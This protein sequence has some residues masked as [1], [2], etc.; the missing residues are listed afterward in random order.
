[1]YI[2]RVLCK[3]AHVHCRKAHPVTL[4]LIP[5]NQDCTSLTLGEGPCM[6]GLARGFNLRGRGDCFNFPVLTSPDGGLSRPGPHFHPDHIQTNIFMH[7]FII[8]DVAFSEPLDVLY[9]H[10]IPQARE[11]CVQCESLATQKA[12]RDFFS[13]E[14][15]TFQ[16]IQFCAPMFKN[17]VG[18]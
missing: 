16:R 6:E 13:Q 4:H 10:A 17:H 7:S 8:K 3:Y 12:R 15:R 18:V 5:H 1:M 11:S 2:C 14:G 9:S